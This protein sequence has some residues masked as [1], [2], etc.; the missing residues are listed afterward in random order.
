[1]AQNRQDSWAYNSAVKAVGIPW[2]T[3]N[4]TWSLG[5]PDGMM[6]L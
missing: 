1:M 5:V 6:G 2:T 3:K 4:H